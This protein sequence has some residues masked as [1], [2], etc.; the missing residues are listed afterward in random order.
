MPMRMQII[1][2][3]A[4]PTLYPGT[5]VYFLIIAGIFHAS[6]KIFRPFLNSRFPP[7]RLRAILY[8]D[9]FAVDMWHRRVLLDAVPYMNAEKPHQ[10]WIETVPY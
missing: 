8:V 7:L 1:H 4:Q 2:H 9:P 5:I 10:G 3:P 6:L